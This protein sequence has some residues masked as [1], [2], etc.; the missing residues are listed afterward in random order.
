MILDQM[1][2]IFDDEYSRL[3]F[4]E[5]NGYYVLWLMISHVMWY[6]IYIQLTSE[7]V[8]QFLNSDHSVSEVKFR[9]FA[10]DVAISRPGLVGRN[11]SWDDRILLRE[12]DR[13]SP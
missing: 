4:D 3:Y 12:D 10:N 2:L 9:H 1:K 8:S 6:D 7:E 11:S 13:D 5:A